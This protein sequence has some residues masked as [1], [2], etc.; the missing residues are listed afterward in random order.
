[1]ASHGDIPQGMAGASG[2][3]LRTASDINSGR[4]IDQGYLWDSW[5]KDVAEL[6]MMVARDLS[7]SDP[8]FSA[9]Y[10]GKEDGQWQAREMRFADVDPKRSRFCVQAWASADIPQTPAGK[11]AYFGELEQ[12]GYVTPEESM[13]NFDV[14]GV[15]R[16][17]SLRTSGRR[18]VEWAIE[19][20]LDRGEY[21]APEPFMPLQTALEVGQQQY[22]ISL[23]EEVAEERLEMLR[24]WILDCQELLAAAAGPPP[25]A[26]PPPEMGAPPMPGEEPMP[27]GPPM[28][29][30]TEMGGAA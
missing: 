24:Q 21:T 13:A 28:P 16:T 18:A 23:Q 8:G 14:P 19:G 11:L 7:R 30:G 3:A 25:G 5:H 4:Q 12:R 22:L 6:D 26:M 15:D 27:P 1:M 29:P 10:L 2:V 9:L 17:L 20:I